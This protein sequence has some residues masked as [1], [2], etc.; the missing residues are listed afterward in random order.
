MLSRVAESIYWMARYVERAENL[1]RFVDVNL[2]LVLDQPAGYAQQWEPL[3]YITGDHD[4]FRD[5]YGVATAENVVRFLTFDEEYPNSIVRVVRAARENSRSIRET[6]SS[7]M[8]EQLNEFHHWIQ[9]ASRTSELWDSPP[10]FFRQV[11]RY[12][13]L[14]S[15]VTDATMTQDLGWHFANL[16]RMLE[17]AD[18][19]SRILDVKYFTLIHGPHELNNPFD[20]LQWSSV[21]RSVSAFEM[22]RKRHH[23]VSVNKVVEFL[24]LNREFPRAIHHCV[25]RAD[26]SLHAISRTA[27]GEWQNAAEKHLG[28]LR[29]Q[30]TFS[31]VDTIV[32]PSLHE[33][34]D[35]LQT[36]LNRVG[37]AIFETFFAAR[38]AA[39]TLAERSG[40]DRMSQTSYGKP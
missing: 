11:K 13:H 27:P 34:I 39:A 22:Y 33:F 5:R 8:W 29:A 20:D 23:S 1:A 17:R 21:L 31:D 7:E 6:I 40:V 26:A 3:V 24:L 35:G 4:W 30:L 12:C 15:G 36:N 38:P 32:V 28:K 9:A 19:V 2:N 25:I 37:E 16:G 18:K 14:F 10:E